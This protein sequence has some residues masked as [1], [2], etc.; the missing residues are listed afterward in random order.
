VADIFV[1]YTSSDRLKAF[2]IG[3]ELKKLGHTPRIHEWEIPAGG[4]I[5]NWMEKRHHD[6]DHV[7]L[8]MSRAYLTAP[9][10]KWERHAA[11]WAAADERPNF[12]LPVFIENFEAPTM[13]AH[14]K[15]CDLYGLSEMEA[16]AALGA[17]LAP[18]AM[19]SAPIAFFGAPGTLAATANDNAGA[20]GVQAGSYYAISNIPF[21]VPRHFLGRDEDMAAI[22]AVLKNSNGRVAITA[23]HGLRGVGKTTLAAAYAERHSGDYRATW[24]IRAETES[25]MRAD[26]AGLGVGLGWVAAD[27]AE[28]PA[29]AAALQRLRDD[30]GG[31]LLVYDNA[32]NQDQIRKYLPRGGAARIIVTS[33][34]SNWRGIAVPVEI[35]VWPAE[36]GAD[37]LTART[38]RDGERVATLILSEALGGLPLAHEQAAAFCDRLGI[39]LAGYLERF[40][41]T[42]AKLLDAEKDAPAE[43]HDRTTV[44]KTFALAI[45]EAAKLYP[46]AELLIVYTSMLAPEPIPLH[47]FSEGL[48]KFSEPFASLIRNGLDEAVAALRAFALIDR[49]HIS[50]ERDHGIT[51]DCIRL[52][53]LVRQVAVA[54]IPSGNDDAIRREL[55]EATEHVFP[56]ETRHG[57][58]EWARARRLDV[59]AAALVRKDCRLPKGS[60][61]AAASLLA[62]LSFYRAK[63]LAAYAEAQ[64][65]SERGLSIREVVLGPDHIDT[66]MS[67]NNI[68]YM[69]H[70]QGEF[71]RAKPYYERALAIVEKTL[72]PNHPDAASNLNN[73]G[74]LLDS[75]G[76]LVGA[77]TYYERSLSILETT[78]EADHPEIA[79][80]LNNLGYL[81]QRLGN[82]PE[83]RALFERALRI[84]ERR[85]GPN[86]PDTALCLNSL[87]SLLEA[88]GDLAG[89]RSYY[90]RSL[91]ILEERLGLAHPY[92]QTIAGNAAS[93]LDRLNLSDQATALRKKFGLEEN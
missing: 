12:A 60:E 82:L 88:E 28:E 65:L 54:R 52:H 49:E 9:Y 72:G 87:A 32:N 14:I 84:R 4:N 76:D 18:A 2:W 91:S 55:I 34:A 90:T 77:R 58:A 33:N 78:L 68:G 31:I 19:P 3:Q 29:L 22:D 51:T 26:L 38:G 27:A 75:Q 25:T 48:E 39:S 5:P 43:Y 74:G 59:I 10:S 44:T 64:D 93:L 92:A 67:H 73:L 30:G 15:R 79:G 61:V 40:E 8:V 7:L 16:R 46:G 13:L 56:D 42:P 23:L 37:Y 63:L 45:D 71:A 83:A 57:V 81:L 62:K 35:E 17:Y 1:S 20:V 86:H 24:W 36:I 6:A 50:D 21:T 69:L 70:L 66:G 11:Q 80:R 53:R 47:L 41:A 85:L 89:A